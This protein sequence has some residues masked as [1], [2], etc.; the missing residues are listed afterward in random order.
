[1]ASFQGLSLTTLPLSSQLSSTVTAGQA[2]GF[3]SDSIVIRIVSPDVPD[4]TLIDLY[5]NSAH[6][7]P[8]PW[9][10]GSTFHPS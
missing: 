1:M 7:L 6:L 3:A 2:S 10:P 5:V 8:F 9:T 4:L